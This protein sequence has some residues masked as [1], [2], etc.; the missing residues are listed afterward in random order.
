MSEESERR[1]SAEQAAEAAMAAQPGNGATE[2]AA[3]V[4][5]IARLKAELEAAKAQAAENQDKFL[6]ARADAENARRRAEIDVANAHKY[7]I[8]RF[9]AELLT[10]RDSL[11]LARA[12]NIDHENQSALA[13]MHEGLDLTLKQM[14][15]VFRKF[16]LTIIDPTGQKF[17]PEKHHAIS[18]VESR[19][20]PPNHVVSVMQKGALLHE[21][22]LRP[23]LV[24]V[25]KAP[26]EAAG[27]APEGEPEA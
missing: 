16:A 4:E 15:D 9:A 1:Q 5:D 18:M 21:R 7:G 22:V 23:A 27:G 26:S 11:E 14:D 19:E 3:P 20:V 2:A 13:K 6:R 25:A 17:D 24:V 10:V 8:E 12:V